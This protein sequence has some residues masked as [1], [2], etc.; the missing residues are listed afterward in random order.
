MSYY[1]RPCRG[2]EPA[3]PR[4]DLTT[5]DIGLWTRAITEKADRSG[6]AQLIQNAGQCFIKRS[7]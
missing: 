2:P 5:L 6:Q 7:R 3:L 1:M 4:A